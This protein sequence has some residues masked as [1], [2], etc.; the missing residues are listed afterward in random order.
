[1][2]DSCAAI[3]I[4]FLSSLEAINLKQHVTASLP[5]EAE[6]YLLRQCLSLAE[7]QYLAT[8]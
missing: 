4:Q 6:L 5:W 2:Q 3:N 8:V 1:M 7:A